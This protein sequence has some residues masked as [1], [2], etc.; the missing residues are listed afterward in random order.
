MTISPTD[1]ALEREDALST[2]K[3]LQDTPDVHR[4]KYEKLI[5]YLGERAM[6]HLELDALVATLED[7]VPGHEIIENVRNITQVQQHMIRRVLEQ[8]NTT[9]EAR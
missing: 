8:M 2:I 7:K 6:P 5:L 1:E 9:R 3:Y 4:T